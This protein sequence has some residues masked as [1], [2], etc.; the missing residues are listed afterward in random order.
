MV[1][2]SGKRKLAAILSADAKDYSRLMDHD[3][4][5][6]VHTLTRYRKVMSDLVRQHRGRVVD[7]PGD[8]LLAEFSSVVD[9]MRCAWDVQQELSIRN[10]EL[11]EDRR[12][13]FRIG[14]NLGDVIEE[15]GRLYGEGV[16]VAARLE[17]L[18]APGG[19][20][21][22][23]TAYDQVKNKLPYQFEFTGEQQVKNI[24]DPV[25]A[26]RVVI[27]SQAPTSGFSLEPKRRKLPPVGRLLLFAT[28][29]VVLATGFYF[30]VDMHVR[31]LSD[32][33]QTDVTSRQMSQKPSIAVLPFKNLSN[34]HQQEYFS[35]GITNDIITELSKFR[36]LIVIAS[37]TVFTYKGKPV[38]VKEV[39]REL[40]V[41]YV[42]EGSTQKSAD[43]VR[44]NAQ[45]IDA[46]T[47]QHVWAQRYDRQL[48]DIFSVQDD[49]V[50]T[51]TGTL[52]VKVN[53][54]ERKRVK[55]KDTANL[56]AYDYVLRGREHFSRITRSSNAKAR[57][58]FQKAIELDPNYATAYVYLGRTY[59]TAVSYGWTEFA[60]P[61]IQQA[62]DLAQK[63][64][65]IEESAA[66]HALLGIVYRYR[67][68]FD[69]AASEMDKAI[70]LNPN[71]AE[72]HATRGAV[73]NY[74][75]HTDEAIQAIQAAQRFDPNMFPR[76]F[77]HLGLAYYLN[78]RYADSIRILEHSIGRYPREVFLHIAL[79]AA[80]AQAGRSEDAGREVQT[81]MKL[82]P[83]FE[84]DSY[85]R[86]FSKPLHRQALVEGLRKAG[87]K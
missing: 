12:M 77:M 63:A 68:Q 84:I 64:L 46:D 54:A 66:A 71:D 5:S 9:A 18:A 79:A 8:N 47:E 3:E 42:L 27:G 82:Y 45:L 2:N 30:W 51:I 4:E 28:G 10:A 69:L 73:L 41:R 20:H 80:Y 7:S 56:A 74:L 35:D 81:V 52:A 83:F 6:T 40:D 57:Q 61:A 44:I 37:N 33:P 24:R 76:H 16:N 60:G 86:A 48:K 19:I 15:K 34:D 31:S 87:L 58:M 22:S 14:I 26:Y 23:G 50:H 70:A 25:R 67:H 59:T 49:I 43:R 53:V 38:K 62:H 85:G 65:S 11:A 1:D 36:D 17:G 21:I 32:K 72:S 13:H 75:G 39:G 78:G 55:H 29:I